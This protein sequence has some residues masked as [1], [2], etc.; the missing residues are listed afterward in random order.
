VRRLK[1]GEV[2]LTKLAERG[3]WES[4]QQGGR[5]SLFER[6]QAEADRILLEHQVQPLEDAQKSELDQIMQAAERELVSGGVV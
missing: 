5:K 3:S 2:L 4:W 1:A 6:A